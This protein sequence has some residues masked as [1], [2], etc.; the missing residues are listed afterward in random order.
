MPRI[1]AKVQA[2]KD[3]EDSAEVIAGSIAI[4]RLKNQRK[5]LWKCL[6]TCLNVRSII[7][8]NRYFYRSEA[9]RY[10][11]DILYDIIH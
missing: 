3:V 10:I 9:G 5:S 11:S 4:L 2:L 7:D 1:T 6:Y 8:S